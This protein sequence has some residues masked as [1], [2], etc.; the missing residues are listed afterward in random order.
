M[1]F[2]CSAFPSAR[3]RLH[4]PPFRGLIAGAVVF[5][6]FAFTALA[7]S[8]PQTAAPGSASTNPGGI[9]ADAGIPEKISA[10]PPHVQD[11]AAVEQR[12]QIAQESAQL[13]QMALELKKAIDNSD[14]STLSMHIVRKADSIAKLAH[15]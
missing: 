13:L 7:Q 4:S 1:R 11:D 3:H 14:S 12:R 9:G 10:Q 6:I 5:G 8:A 2:N 15:G